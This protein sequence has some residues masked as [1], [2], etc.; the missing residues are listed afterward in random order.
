MLAS[1]AKWWATPRT[2]QKVRQSS[3]H[4]AGNSLETRDSIHRKQVGRDYTPRNIYY[5]F[6]ETFLSGSNIS[7]SK[8]S[9][10]RLHIHLN[11]FMIGCFVKPRT[12]G[13][14]V[15]MISLSSVSTCT[16]NF[17]QLTQYFFILTRHRILNLALFVVLQSM[18]GIY[19][20]IYKLDYTFPVWRRRR[21]YTWRVCRNV[22]NLRLL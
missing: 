4:M 6:L 10:Q 11:K 21:S 17:S 5:V 13:A 14:A 2:F 9:G 15:T 8:D 19:T 1:L 22:G 12:I 3:D 16:V 7:N 20:E 18:G